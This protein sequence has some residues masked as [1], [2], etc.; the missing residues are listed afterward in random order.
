MADERLRELER[1]AAAGNPIAQ[2]RWRRECRRAGV[3]WGEVLWA[4]AA[5]SLPASASYLLH[6]WEPGALEV[7]TRGRLSPGGGSLCS[8]KES[9]LVKRVAARDGVNGFRTLDA[10]LATYAARH[11]FCSPCKLCQRTL[12]L[13]E[14]KAARESHLEAAIA[15]LEEEQASLWPDE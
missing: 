11:Q 2:E 9:K 1:E 6:A 10:W 14:P 4:P 8:I 7:R 13:H 15:A 5:G 3:T 12:R